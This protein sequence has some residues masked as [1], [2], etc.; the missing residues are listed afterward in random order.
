[1]AKGWSVGGRLKPPPN[2]L[3]ALGGRIR[4]RV[5]VAEVTQVCEELQSFHDLGWWVDCVPLED[6]FPDELFCRRVGAGVVVVVGQLGAVERIQDEIDE[7]LRGAR[8]LRSH[9]NRHGVDP[10]RRTL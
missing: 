2:D 8:M 6:L 9:R 4:I 1:M 5:V 7:R 3:L 10:G